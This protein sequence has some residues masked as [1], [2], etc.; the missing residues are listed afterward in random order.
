MKSDDLMTQ[1]I[2]AR[3]QICRNLNCPRVAIANENIRSPV[4][5]V[6]GHVDETLGADLEELKLSLVHVLTVTR[7]FGQVVD[8]RAFVGLGPCVPLEVD[9]ITSRHGD[10][11]SGV[12]SSPV[13]N[14]IRV[15]EAIRFDVS[16]ISSS[17]N[18]SSNWKLTRILIIIVSL[19]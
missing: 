3:S 14:D 13:T 7:T 1:N 18:P 19:V 9:F 8:N 17:S 11:A 16:I 6:H 12:S 15:C 4:A 5:A 10:M 2:V